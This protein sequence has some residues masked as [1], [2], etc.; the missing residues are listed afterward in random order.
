MKETKLFAGMINKNGF[1]VIELMVVL[2][3]FSVVV[4]I[5]YFAYTIMISSYQTTARRVE[6]I[7]LFADPMVKFEGDFK[8]CQRA[9]LDVDGNLMLDFDTTQQMYFFNEKNLLHINNIDGSQDTICKNIIGYNFQYVG[10]PDESARQEV[11]SIEIHTLQD[12]L[13]FG[14]YVNKIYDNA[15]LINTHLNERNRY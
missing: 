14:V 9:Y 11:V 4:T 12:S 1:T 8:T 5:S 2:L 7:K 6:L 13:N 3:L 10:Q 15:Y